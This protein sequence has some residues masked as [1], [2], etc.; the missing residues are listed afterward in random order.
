MSEEE[1]QGPGFTVRDRRTFDSEGKVKESV[2]AEKEEDQKKDKDR[3]EKKEK[4][5]APLPEVNFSSFLLSLSSSSL[6]HLGEIADPQSGEKKKDLALA[7][8]SIDII[9]LLKDKTKGNLTQEEEN[10]LDHLLHDL[11]MRFVKASEQ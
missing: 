1:I 5:T 3:E 4:G 10:L 6:L 11:R 2:R 7:K 9:S 8:Q